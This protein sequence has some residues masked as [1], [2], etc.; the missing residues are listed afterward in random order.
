[1]MMNTTLHQLRSLKLEGLAQALEQQLGQSGI[2]AMSFEERIALLVDR[3]VHGRQDRRC[4][5]LLKLARLKYPQ[6]AIE[7]LDSRPT[8]GV[9]RS[10]VMSLVLGQ[11]VS[12]GH[13][14]MITGPTG[15]GKSWLAC[16]LAQHACRR[17]HSAYYQRVPRLGEELR[18]RHANGT[19]THWLDALKKTDVLLLDDW[20]MSAIDAHTRADLMEIIDDRAAS[21]ATII[22]SQLPIEHWHEWI[23]DATMADAMLDRLMQHHH[24]FTLTGESRRKPEPTAADRAPADQAVKKKPAAQRPG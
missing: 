14:V 7:D 3:E 8:R 5:R 11:W 2:G 4:A 21:R 24:R 22:T 9:Q 18:I 10:E 15:A 19:F 1:M 23:G 6:A 12:A 20:G 16:A 17:G 13:A